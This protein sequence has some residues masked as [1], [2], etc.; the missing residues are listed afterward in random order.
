LESI[1]ADLEVIEKFGGQASMAIEI[2]DS[3]SAEKIKLTNNN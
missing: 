2:I 3:Y 1:I